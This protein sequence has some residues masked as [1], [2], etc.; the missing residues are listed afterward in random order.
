MILNQKSSRSRINEAMHQLVVD[1]YSGN[2]FQSYLISQ[3][4]DS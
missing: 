2:D 3:F 1:L 4:K